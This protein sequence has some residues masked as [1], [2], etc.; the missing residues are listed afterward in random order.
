M[1][2]DPGQGKPNHDACLPCGLCSSGMQNLHRRTLQGILSSGPQLPV[3]LAL[4][5]QVFTLQGLLY[6]HLALATSAIYHTAA[7]KE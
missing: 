4:D 3:G 7:A 2:A 6:P 1:G 5:A